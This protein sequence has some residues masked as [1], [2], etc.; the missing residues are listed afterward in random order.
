[1]PVQLHCT[2]CTKRTN[3][4]CSS[5]HFS[6]FQFSSVHFSS[7]HFSSFQFS[8]FQFSSVHFSSFHFSS[9]REVYKVSLVKFNSF[10]LHALKAIQWELRK[11]PGR[12]RKNWMDIIRRDLKDMDTTWD[13]DE[14]L[15]TDRAEWR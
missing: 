4:Q 13:E 14:E 2:D 5:F 12:P 9:F 8:S 10:A 11:T 1:M 15:A 7:F 6:S 3:W